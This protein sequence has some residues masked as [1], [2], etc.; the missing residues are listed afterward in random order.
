MTDT[1][2][3]PPLSGLLEAAAGAA[4]GYA[5]HLRALAV[6]ADEHDDD[7]SRRQAGEYR[8]DASDLDSAGI[9]HEIEAAKAARLEGRDFRAQQRNTQRARSIGQDQVH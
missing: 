5:N 6:R 8:R 4:H 2:N 3:R 9:L 7:E 1:S